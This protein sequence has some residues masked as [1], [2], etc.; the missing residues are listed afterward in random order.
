MTEAAESFPASARP[1]PRSSSATP[2][3]ARRRRPWRRRSA[4]CSTARALHALHAHERALAPQRRPAHRRRA[5]PRHGRF[6]EAALGA[7]ERTGGLVDATLLHELEDA[8]T[9]A[10]STSR[11][12][13]AAR[14]SWRPSAAPPPRT[15]HG[16][17]ARSASTA[18]P[19]RARRAWPSTPAA[20]PRASSPT[21]SPP[22][23][24]GTRASPSTAGATCASAGR[25]SARVRVAS[26]FDGATLHT[27]V[28]AKGGVAT[29]GIGRRAWRD[30]TGA[31]PTI[32]STR[33][34]AAPRT[35]GS[36]RPR[37]SRPPRWRPRCAP[38]RRPERP[39]RRAPV[40]A[41]RWRARLRRRQPRDHPKETSP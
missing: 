38:R 24:P 23:S 19:S 32:S 6:V 31:P 39:V 4:A 40:A 11:C 3:S 8:A 33:R 21:C 17:G 2:R 37:R 13:S 10:T 16:A 15:P 29:S 22:S 1:A 12:R 35:P 41:P 5:H 28:I 36:C 18:T 14:W 27:Y 20:W 25:S 26:P 34:P 9:A 30:A 7:A